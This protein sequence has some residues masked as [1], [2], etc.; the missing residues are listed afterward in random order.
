MALHGTI[1]TLDLHDPEL[2]ATIGPADGI[3]QRPSHANQSDTRKNSL[4]LDAWSIASLREQGAGHQ[5]GFSSISNVVAPE[6]SATITVT[7]RPGDDGAPTTST[8][9]EAL[10]ISEA[11]DPRAT[12]H[13]GSVRGM[14]VLAI[15]C[16]AQLIDNVL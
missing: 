13:I 3:S 1:S 11:A 7:T 2:A 9:M 10:I 8:T 14:L 12:G 6:N 16:T 4:D 15:T 5:T